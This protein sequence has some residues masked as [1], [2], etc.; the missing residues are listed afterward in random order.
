MPT[1]G[2]P[3]TSTAE[4]MRDELVLRGVERARIRLETQGRNTREQAVEVRTLLAPEARVL[5][6]SSA[7]HLR[8]ARLAFLRAGFPE[9]HAAPAVESHREARRRFDPPPAGMPAPTPFP[10]DLGPHLAFRYAFWNQ[11]IYLLESLRELTA[12][13][14]YKLRG[15][16]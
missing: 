7:E 2:L 11:Q 10:T 12:L 3:G 1:D 4:G 6:V 16:A 15:W 14:W 13:A 9:V 8:R 5:L